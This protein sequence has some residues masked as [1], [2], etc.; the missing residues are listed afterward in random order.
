MRDVKVSV[1]KYFMNAH[2]F[3]LGLENS[4]SEVEVFERKV[5]GPSAAYDVKA[6]SVERIFSIDSGRYSSKIEFDKL[7]ALEKYNLAPKAFKYDEYYLE[8]P[9]IITEKLSG[10]SL[11]KE[12]LEEKLDL[13]LESISSLSKINLSELR[14]NACYGNGPRNCPNSALSYL[15]FLEED[16]KILRGHFGNNGLIKFSNEFLNQAKM[17]VYRNPS[18]FRGPSLSLVHSLLHGRNIIVDD[19]NKVKFLNW[20][21]SS[22]GDKALE[23]SRLIDLNNLSEKSA[24]KAINYYSQSDHSFEERVKFYSQLSNLDWAIGNAI[25]YSRFHSIESK[26]GFF[27]NIGKILEGN[28]SENS[29]LKSKTKT[30]KFLED[31]RVYP[32]WQNVK[33]YARRTAMAGLAA[34]ALYSGACYD[35]RKPRVV[36]HY[37]NIAGAEL[38]IIGRKNYNFPTIPFVEDLI[39][40]EEK[41]KATKYH[42]GNMAVQINEAQN[43]RRVFRAKYSAG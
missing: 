39:W 21:N 32:L 31:E 30:Q 38:E 43:E 24:N 2:P 35:Q 29:G 16:T 36:Q 17:Y 7:E 5:H 20:A 25:Q 41:T 11:D 28:I 18:T 27:E 40:P 4:P 33:K 42:N 13:V 23:I 26:N 14:K 10:N 6:D 37:D 34:L 22:I 8:E 9:F 15:Q 3:D 12:R 19:Q 1:K